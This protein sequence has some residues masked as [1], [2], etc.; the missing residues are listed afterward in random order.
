MKNKLRQQKENIKNIT[1]KQFNFDD[2]YIQKLDKNIKH[3]YK[4]TTLQRLISYCLMFR[5]LLKKNS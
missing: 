4:K 5:L 1:T 2:I 3:F